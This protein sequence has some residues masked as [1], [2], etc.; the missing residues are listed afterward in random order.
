MSK[1][2]VALWFCINQGHLSATLVRLVGP[3]Y[4]IFDF[5]DGI[6]KFYEYTFPQSIKCNYLKVLKI[7]AYANMHILYH[8]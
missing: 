8:N 2:S 1:V 7:D 4:V 5:P 6:D 3:A